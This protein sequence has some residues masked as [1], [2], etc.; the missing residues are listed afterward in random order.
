LVVPPTD[1][2]SSSNI[3]ASNRSNPD[4]HTPRH[5]KDGSPIER[6]NYSSSTLQRLSW[7][8]NYSTH[9]QRRSCSSST[10]WD[11]FG[12]NLE[13]WAIIIIII[14]LLFLTL[15]VIATRK[16]IAYGIVI[17]WALFGIALK[18]TN[19]NIMITAQA[20]VIIILIIFGIRSDAGQ[21]E[22]TIA[23]FAMIGY[24]W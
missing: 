6:E 5:R 16:D 8:D 20:S 11:G 14:A 22:K 18:Q 24:Q 13:T 17:V 19:P 3:G 23:R 2:I 21:T 7:L 15:T 1:S 4:L 12:I 10:N 9:S